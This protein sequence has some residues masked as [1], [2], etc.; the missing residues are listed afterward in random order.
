M[1]R[2]IRKVLSTDALAVEQD[3]ARHFAVVGFG[4]EPIDA[5]HQG[6]LSTAA[7]T[8]QQQHFPRVQLQVDILNGW[9]AAGVI[10]EGKLPD[11]E[12]QNF[13]FRHSG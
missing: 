9:C 7:G 2:N 8:R 12:R 10:A 3:I 1:L 5:A 4:D 6:G 11:D 13:R